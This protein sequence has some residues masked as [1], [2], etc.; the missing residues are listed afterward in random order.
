MTNNTIEI[1]KIKADFKHPDFRYVVG[2]LDELIKNGLSVIHFPGGFYIR[3]VTGVAK[4]RLVI[5]YI[6]K[7][8]PDECWFLDDKTTLRLWWD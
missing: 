8:K 2:Y 4:A 7:T 3:N 1:E 6:G 5:K